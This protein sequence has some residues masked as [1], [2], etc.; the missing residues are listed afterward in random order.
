MHIICSDLEGVFI[1]EIWINVAERT[2]IADLRLTTRDISDYDV[3]MKRRL[4]ILDANGLKLKDITDVIATMDPMPGAREFLDWLRARTQVVIVS[5]TFVEFARPLMEKLGWPTLLCHGL[6]IDTRGAIADYN[7]RQADGKRKV[8]QAFKT[9]N[10][11]V[12]AM[13]DSYNDVN[14]LK[15]AD[16]GVLFRPPQNVIDE[17][18][19]FPVATTYAELK[20]IFGKAIGKGI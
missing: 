14:M 4:S 9:L 8:V 6:T 16:M 17:Y 13:G 5:D 3:L 20:K 15:E 10:Y 12:L 7:L 11:Q 2:G 19:Q 18:P 1:P